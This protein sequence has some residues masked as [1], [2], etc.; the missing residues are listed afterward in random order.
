MENYKKYGN[1]DG[2]GAME[3][4]IALPSWIVDPENSFMILTLYFFMFMVVMPA[5]V[6]RWWYSKQK[7]YTDDIMLNT[8]KVF[9]RFLGGGRC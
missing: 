1:P 5:L 9:S 7:E 6:G 8:M 3:Y 2:P 4:G